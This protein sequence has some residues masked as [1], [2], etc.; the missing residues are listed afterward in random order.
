M[1][2][3]LAYQG[4]EIHPADLIVRPTHSLLLQSQF[5]RENFVDDLPEFMNG[6]FPTNGDGY[7]MGWYGEDEIP[8]RYRELRPAWSDENLINIAGHVKSRLFLAHLRA[9]YGNVVQR[10]NNHPFAEGRWLFQHNGEIEGFNAVRRALL[11]H[12]APEYF[13]CIV[14]TTDSEVMFYLALTLGLDK[15]P[16]GAM[17]RMVGLVEHELARAGCPGPLRLTC[18]LADGQ[19]IYAVRY[20]SSGPAKSLYRNRDARALVQIAKGAEYE[21]PEGGQLF[22][23]EPLDFH[24]EHWEE[25]PHG[26]FARLRHGSVEVDSF[27]PETP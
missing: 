23:S 9:A 12:V 6:A 13:N 22:V 16:K 5:A 14:G 3:W 7:G 15:D 11:L 8:C 24:R 19:C 17:Q 27:R 26:S 18:A 2:R 25:I 10:S 20:A 4:P 21:L 1:C